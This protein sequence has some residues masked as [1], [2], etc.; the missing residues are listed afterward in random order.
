[1]TLRYKIYDGEFRTED[2]TRTLPASYVEA[3][4]KAPD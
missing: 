3:L 4:D 1:M 2:D